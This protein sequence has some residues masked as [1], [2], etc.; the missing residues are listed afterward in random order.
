MVTSNLGEVFPEN[1]LIGNVE[2]IVKTGAD[3]FQKANVKPFFNLK[4]AELVFVIT[5]LSL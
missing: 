5:S 1:L 2:K 3:P 4:S